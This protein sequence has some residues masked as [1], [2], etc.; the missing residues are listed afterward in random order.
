M[1]TDLNKHAVRTSNSIAEL[2]DSRDELAVVTRKVITKVPFLNEYTDKEKDILGKYSYK[3][4][5]L[6]T[7]YTANKRIIHG[8]KVSQSDASFLQR[9][10]SLVS[11]NTI[12]WTELASKEIKKIDLREDYIVTQAVTIQ[13]LGR[14]GSHFYSDRTLSMEKVLKRLQQIN[15]RRD[16]QIWRGRTIRANGRILTSETATMLTSNAII[17]V[18]GIPFTSEEKRREDLFLSENGFYSGEQS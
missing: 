18:L 6:N 14:V 1:F 4:F 11:K 3:L 2:Y 16:N 8:T 10:W 15:W 12:P 5:T 13:A 17:S 9:F 7:F